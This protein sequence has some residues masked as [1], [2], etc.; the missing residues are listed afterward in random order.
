M[1]KKFLVGYLERM[2]KGNYTY[3]RIY[4]PR[5][6]IED[7]LE[8]KNVKKLLMIPTIVDGKLC[9]LVKPYD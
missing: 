1:E 4:I 3:Y 5:H 8:W 6:I 2:R 9:L 7:V